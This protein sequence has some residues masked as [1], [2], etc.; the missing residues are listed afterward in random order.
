[1]CA[2]HYENTTML[3]RVSAENVVDVFLRQCM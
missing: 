2:K 1:M 3:F